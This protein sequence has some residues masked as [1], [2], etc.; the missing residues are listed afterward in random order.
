M[1]QVLIIGAGNFGRHLIAAL[2]ES[3]CA[4]D[5]LD[6]EAAPCCEAQHLG[7]R[8]IRDN[9]WNLSGRKDIRFSDYDF[10]YLCLPDNQPLNLHVTESL[11]RVGAGQIVVRVKRAREAEFYLRAGAD[12]VV[13][14]EQFASRSL[15]QGMAGFSDT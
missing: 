4:V 9:A 10:C 13:C 8:V 11:R 15:V 12:Q 14:P 2:L 5:V 6:K 3:G 1:K 7:C